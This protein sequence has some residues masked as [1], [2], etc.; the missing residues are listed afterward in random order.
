MNEEIKKMLD[1]IKHGI[2][3]GEDKLGIKVG[4]I[5]Y[6]WQD[7]KLLYDYITKLQQQ[8]RVYKRHYIKRINMCID[9]R[10]KCKSYQLII[11]KAIEYIKNNINIYDIDGSVENLDEFNILASPK[12]LLNI[13]K[14]SDENV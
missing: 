14:G 12:Y 4:G 11:Y 6:E 1:D 10:E 13:L 5:C 8:N 7:L 2:D 3:T 9:L